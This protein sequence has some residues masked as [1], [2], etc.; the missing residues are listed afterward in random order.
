[1]TAPA[2]WYPDPSGKPIQR[3]F[4]GQMWTE[5]CAA[6]VSESLS[7]MIPPNLFPQQRIGVQGVQ[8]SPFPLAVRRPKQQW[9]VIALAL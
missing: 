6:Q 1:M 7:P 8:G 2:G 5:H 9:L 3:Y 4:D